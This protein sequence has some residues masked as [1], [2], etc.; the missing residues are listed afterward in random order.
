MFP[1]EKDT[2]CSDLE[3]QQ[4]VKYRQLIATDELT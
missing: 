4:I 3:V 2:G 1:Q